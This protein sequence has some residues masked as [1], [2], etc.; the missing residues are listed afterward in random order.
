MMEGSL[1]T[2]TYESHI[3]SMIRED[4]RHMF[5]TRLISGIVLVVIAL[6]T[7][8]TGG[9]LLLATLLFVSL[10]GM[11]ELYGAMGIVRPNS[12]QIRSEL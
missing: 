5:T 9:P 12:A 8:I 11:H 1:H 6:V 2:N 10:V 3:C 4:M 7:I